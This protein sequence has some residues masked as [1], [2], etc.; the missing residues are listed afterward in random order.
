[1]GY[2][3]KKIEKGE[4]GTF[5]KIKEEFEEFEDAVNQQDAILQLI[6][7][8]DLIGAIEE[9]IRPQGFIIKDLIDFSDKTKSA[10]VDGSR[11]K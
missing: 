4:Y 3:I 1:M 8:S 9:Y 6:E 5:S 7:L 2:H 11:T 10:F